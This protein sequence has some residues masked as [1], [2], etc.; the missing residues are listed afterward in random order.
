MKRRGFGAGFDSGSWCEMMDGLDT[1]S[2]CTRTSAEPGS[3][4]HCK[5]CVRSAL[6]DALEV[7]KEPWGAVELLQLLRL[8]C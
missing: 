4:W 1:K 6:S 5:P 2:R 3:D 7:P 8:L